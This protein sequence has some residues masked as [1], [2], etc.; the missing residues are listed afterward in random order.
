VGEYRDALGVLALSAE[1]RVLVEENWDVEMEGV[2]EREMQEDQLVVLILIA[3]SRSDFGTVLS[4]GGR[5]GR[6]RPE[7]D[8]PASSDGDGDVSS[9]AGGV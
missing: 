5:L 7:G 4:Q 1:S 6:R 8:V 2:Q 9:L 3:R